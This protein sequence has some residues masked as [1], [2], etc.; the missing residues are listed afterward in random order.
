[1]TH[2][3]RGLR[4][5]ASCIMLL[6]ISSTTI[7]AEKSPAPVVA[8][9]DFQQ[10]TRNS[11]AGAI[12]RTQI[13]EQHA[14]FQKEIQKSQAELENERQSIQEKQK[15]LSPEKFKKLSGNYR[16]K[17]EKLQILVQRRKQQ[18]DQMYVNGMRT[19]E[20]ELSEI[21]RDIAKERGIDLILN[22]TK[23][24]GIVIY[25]NPDFVITKEAQSRLDKRLPEV[26][27]VLPSENQDTVGRPSSIGKP[28]E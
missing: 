18:L 4:Y 11:S 25:A 12:I 20:S 2:G 17:A 19:V 3:F 28:K 22:T 7:A 16:A 14:V 9:M 24:Q 23:G 1:M 10:V 8:I 13:N 27:L 6:M 26:T 21:V 15:S 5:A